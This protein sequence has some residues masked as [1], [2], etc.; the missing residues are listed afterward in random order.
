MPAHAP[1][2]SF[3]ARQDRPPKT[4]RIRSHPSASIRIHPHPSAPSPRL[5]PTATQAPAPRL[6]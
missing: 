5:P 1:T 4:V 3:L 2:A 6:Q